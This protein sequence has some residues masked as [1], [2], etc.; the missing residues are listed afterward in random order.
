MPEMG[1]QVPGLAWKGIAGTPDTK[2]P[3]HSS[4]TIGTASA[5]VPLNSKRERNS[6]SGF[7][8]PFN[9]PIWSL[10]R[11]TTVVPPPQSSASPAEGGQQLG[12][13]VVF[14]AEMASWPVAWDTAEVD[15]GKGRCGAGAAGATR[16]S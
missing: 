11:R 16:R 12:R 2:G 10:S 6:V 8:F 9:P 5:L 1:T 7:L 14:S 4:V 3:F 13:A 15:M